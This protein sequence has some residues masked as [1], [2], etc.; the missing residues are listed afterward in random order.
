LHYIIEKQK[1]IFKLFKKYNTIK[2]DMEHNILR[3]RDIIIDNLLIKKKI[4]VGHNIYNYPIK[5]MNNS[6]IIQT[7]ILTMPFGKYSYGTKSYIDASFINDVVD[8]DMVCFKDIV[9]KTNNFVINYISKMNKKIK[10]ISSIKN[11][12][13]LYSDRIRLNIQ[14]DILVFNET[15]Q[16]LD[17][18]YLKAKAY[19]KFLISPIHIWQNEDK[20]GITWSLLQAKVYPQTVLNI[21]SFLDDKEDKPSNSNKYKSHPKYQKYF[22]MISCGVPKEAVKHKMIIDNLDPNVLD[23]DTKSTNKNENKKILEKNKKINNL[24]NS[25]GTMF[26]SKVSVPKINIMNEIKLAKLK[27]VDKKEKI[28]K[29]VKDENVYNPPSLTQILEMRKKLNKIK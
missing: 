15:K 27:K 24:N 23:N 2:I 1:N 21:Y 6:L 11:S 28:L 17:H 18:N 14:E 19:V 3:P 9:S 7:P 25:L 12:N 16:L 22:K 5:Y 20:Y 13:E 8:K 4:N 26:A 29:D 10:F